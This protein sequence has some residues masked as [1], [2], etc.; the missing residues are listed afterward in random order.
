MDTIRAPEAARRN[1]GLA[2]TLAAFA[3]Y[4]MWGLFPLYWKRLA[5]VDAL[6]ILCHRIVWSALLTLVLLAFRKGGLRELHGLARSG[7]RLAAAALA[8]ALISVNWGLYIWAVN[9]GKVADSSLGYFINPLL[10]IALGAIFLGERLDRGTK[11]AVA[12]ATLGVAFAGFYSGRL[13]WISLALAGTFGFYGLVKKKAGLDPLLGLAAETL[14]AAPFALAWL[15][16]EHGAGRGAF[17]SPANGGGGTETAMLFLAGIVTALPLLAFAFA[18]NRIPL[19]RLGFI[20]YLS[21]T[22]QLALGVLVYGERPDLGRVGAFGA[23]AVAVAIYAGTRRR[24]AAAA[25]AA[26]AKR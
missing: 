8:S 4:G 9:S 5:S 25:S 22:G 13:P 26:P 6:Q 19:Q 17:G 21:P 7:K 2:G 16:L 18:A 23:V 15:V 24:A 3:A 1:A 14:I 10:S 11:A 20:Q 12:V